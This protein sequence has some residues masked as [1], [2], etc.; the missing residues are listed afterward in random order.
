MDKL[1]IIQD[2][3][4]DIFDD[5]GL[6]LT[7]DTSPDDIEDWD[8]FAQVTIVLACES[9]FQIKFDL[10]DIAKIKNV[11]DLLETIDQKLNKVARM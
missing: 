5:E 11:G 9:A 1:N 4:R 6:V 7:I 8:S 2:V 10:N 3:F